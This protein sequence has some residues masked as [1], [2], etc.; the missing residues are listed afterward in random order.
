[1]LY[2]LTYSAILTF[3]CVNVSHSFKSHSLLAVLSD[4]LLF[5]MSNYAA[6]LTTWC[7]EGFAVSNQKFLCEKSLRAALNVSMLHVNLW[8]NQ[9]GRRQCIYCIFTA[10]YWLRI[11]GLTVMNYGLKTGCCCS[12]TC[13]KVII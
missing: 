13:T 1:M 7:W 4:W 8:G 11:F 9:K 12:P 6:S 10:F 3:L 5:G 2:L